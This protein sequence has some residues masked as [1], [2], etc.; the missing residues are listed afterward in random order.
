MERMQ[1][2]DFD[3]IE[4]TTEFKQC[5]HK[6]VKLYELGTHTDY[7]CRF[8]KIKSLRLSDFDNN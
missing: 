3:K 7:G 2:K 1:E 8:C 5:D 6:V 4:Q